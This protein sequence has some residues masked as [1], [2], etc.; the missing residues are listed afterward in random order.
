MEGIELRWMTN[1]QLND[2]LVLLVKLLLDGVL[3]LAILSFR[4]LLLCGVAAD[5][6]GREGPNSRH[7]RLC[8]L[9]QRLRC[10]R[11]GGDDGAD[12]LSLSEDG[13]LEHYEW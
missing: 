10:G 7:T 13:S 5:G 8:C 1:L 2:L 9:T 12:G 6:L 11:R 4:C 3:G